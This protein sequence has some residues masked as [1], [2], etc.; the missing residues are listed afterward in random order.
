MFRLIKQV[1]T[2]GMIFS[3]FLVSKAMPLNNESCVI[4]PTLININL[5]QLS[6][7]TLIISQGKYKGCYPRD[8]NLSTEACVPSKTIDVNVRIF[9]MI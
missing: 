5:I 9:N 6:Y 1:F 2:A 4:R 7:Y 8:D 3:G